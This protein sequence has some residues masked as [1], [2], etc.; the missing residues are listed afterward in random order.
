MF[1]ASSTGKSRP[2]SD[3]QLLSGAGVAAVAGFRLLSTCI[4]HTTATNPP[5]LQP[6]I[7]ITLPHN[8]K[9]LPLLDNYL[10]DSIFNFADIGNCLLLNSKILF[11]ILKVVCSL[12][13][14]N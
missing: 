13:I 6:D 3:H 2:N 4:L 11:D 14:D 8:F 9:Q 5:T 7:L 12:N 10:T 1:V